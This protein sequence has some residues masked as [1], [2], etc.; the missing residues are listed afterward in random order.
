MDVDEFSPCNSRNRRDISAGSATRKTRR[1]KSPASVHLATIGPRN[2]N[3]SSVHPV[4][5]AGR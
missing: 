4:S 2:S 3:Q 5:G 1:V